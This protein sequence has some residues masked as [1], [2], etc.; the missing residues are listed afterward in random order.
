MTIGRPRTE[1]PRRRP[2]SP[3]YGRVG[4]RGARAAFLGTGPAAWYDGR[5]LLTTSQTTLTNRVGTS[6]ATLTSGPVALP[7]TGT[8]YVHL[9][10][11]ASNSL[12][13]PD[14]AALSITGDIDIIVSMAGVDWTPASS[15]TLLAKRGGAGQVSWQFR[16]ATTG[17]PELAW[18]ADGT[19]VTATSATAST[20]FTDGARGWVR[21][22]VDVD[23]GSSNSDFKFY[24]S[25][26]GVSWSQ[27]GSTVNGGSV[28][29]FFDSTQAV[30][31]GV[32]SGTGSPFACTFHRAIIKNGIDGTT[33]LDINPATE[34]LGHATW[35]CTTGQTVTVNRS[36]SGYTTAV[37]DRGRVMLDGSNDRIVLA[38]GDTP[39]FTAA[40]GN[41]TVMLINRV[42]NLAGAATL[43][44]VW[45]S[46]SASDVGAYLYLDQTNAQYKALVGGATTVATA[47][48]TFTAT[49]Q[50]H[51]VAAVFAAGTAYAYTTTTGLTAGAD[52]S[53]V[54]TVTHAAAPA[55]GSRADSAA[56]TADFA[57]YAVVHW[58]RALTATELATAATYLLGAYS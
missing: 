21:V 44:R 3:R 16:L 56:N 15:S 29:S 55:V 45:S 52:Y 20:G 7:H 19:A 47:A 27:L 37:V 26:D 14:S 17:R 23:N 41:Y 49:T 25:T 18:S 54:G 6:T 40:A 28:V 53:G 50:L 57:C 33:V 36:T 4:T 2:P 12:S 39:T 8:S 38:A 1:A 13:V 42:H 24:T 46:E 51:A 11:T 9:P 34:T 35:T 32:F 43:S 58:T 30:E 22:T 10:G 5:D 48:A 31:V